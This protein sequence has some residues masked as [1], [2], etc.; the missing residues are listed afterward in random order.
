MYYKIYRSNVHFILFQD[1]NAA[2][3]EDLKKIYIRVKEVQLK[4]M[5]GKM[6]KK[7]SSTHY[8]LHEKN[9]GTKTNF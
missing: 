2:H 4:S 3:L 9:A 1:I 7:S 6:S 8:F 5:K